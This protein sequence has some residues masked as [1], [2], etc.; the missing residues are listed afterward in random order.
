MAH[1]V[2][3]WQALVRDPDQAAS[4]YAATFGWSV[5]DRNA[6]GYR[7]IPSAGRGIGGGIWPIPD[8]QPMVQLFVEVPDV[9]AA[10][11]AASAHGGQIVM[12]R[13]VL[14]D[15][16]EMAVVAGPEGIAWGLMRP[17]A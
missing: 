13:Q 11:A 16:D 17:R 1:P 8:G 12:P 10:L 6:L 9:E 7:A 2:V 14:P 4:F 15:G 5:D 3:R